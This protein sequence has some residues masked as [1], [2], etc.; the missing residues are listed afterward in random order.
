MQL[1]DNYSKIAHW[2][3]RASLAGIFIFHGFIKFPMAGMMADQMGMPTFV[4]YVLALMEILGGIFII[5]GALFNELLTR[6]AGAIFAV[7]MFGAI[8]MVHWPQWSFVA[9]ESH[10]MGG[11]EFQLLVLLIGLYFLSTGNK[12]FHPEASD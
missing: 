9:S 1:L 4:V 6:I 11:M 12:T 7:V 5:A 2:F 10:P 8:M 3:I